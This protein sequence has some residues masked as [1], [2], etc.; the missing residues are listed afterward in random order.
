MNGARILPFPGGRKRGLHVKRALKGILAIG[1]TSIILAGCGGGSGGGRVSISPITGPSHMQVG[2]NSPSSY[3]FLA[4]VSGSNDTSIRWSTSDSSLATIDATTG[5]ATPSA[6]RTGTVTIIATANADSTTQST[7]QVGI[8]DWILAGQIQQMN[9]LPV[10][11]AVER[12]NSDGT[13]P[14]TLIPFSLFS[15]N[16]YIN[17]IWAHDHLSFACTP[18]FS[19]SGSAPTELVIFQTDGTAAG[20]RQSAIIDLIALGFSGTLGNAQFSPDGSKIVFEGATTSSG[21]FLVAGTYLVATN[22]ESGPVLLAT[23]PSGYDAVVGNPR[24]TPD[25]SEILYSQGGTVWIMNADGSNQRQL[26]ATTSQNAEFSPDMSTLFYSS[27]SG[28]FRAN[29]DGSNP[30]NIAASGYTFEG[31]SPNGQSI[32][33]VTAAPLGS[34]GVFTANSEGG[35]LQGLDASD[36]ASW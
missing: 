34:G 13:N 29:A 15:M 25:G 26:L 20:T 18:M 27:V 24:F 21:G 3:I 4:T 33:L 5:I 31:L 6:T 7:V 11:L 2:V 14:V 30:V 16:N 22:G 35:N 28:V 36:W 10:G 8:V 1:L 32:L 17:C 12:M 9:G 23:D 19:S